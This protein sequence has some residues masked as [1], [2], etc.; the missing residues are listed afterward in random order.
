MAT[1]VRSPNKVIWAMDEAIE[2]DADAAELLD[3]LINA[4]ERESE[5]ARR[6]FDKTTQV[7]LGQAFV[8]LSRLQAHTARLASLHRQARRNEYDR[9]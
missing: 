4:L 7:R 6:R 3:S 2:H 5:E 9:R 1:A 8:T